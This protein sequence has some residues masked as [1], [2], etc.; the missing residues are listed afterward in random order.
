M[1]IFVAG[2]SGAI[3]TRLVPQL[4]EH[5][6][7]V[8]G[9]SR[10]DAGLERLRALGAQPVRLDLLD[11]DAV[12]NAVVESKP[13]AIVHE[14]TALEAKRELGWTL[15]Y[16]S[17]RRGPRSRVRAIRCQRWRRG[18]GW[19]YDADGSPRSRDSPP[20]RFVLTRSGHREQQHHGRDKRP[21]AAQRRGALSARGGGCPATAGLD[22]RL[23]PR[24][25]PMAGLQGVGTQPNLYPSQPRPSGRAASD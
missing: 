19:G 12:V 20:S 10:S 21:A 23:H 14:A 5:G 7:Q 1:R 6:H 3:G 25:P 8:I 16:P 9:T 18:H 15:R 11:R 13:D 22:D 17:W 24:H 4:I 2:A